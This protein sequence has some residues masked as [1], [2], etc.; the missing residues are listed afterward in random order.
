VANELF[1]KGIFVEALKNYDI[2]IAY[3]PQYEKAHLNKAILLD[4]MGKGR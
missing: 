4:K 3:N 1:G 2:A